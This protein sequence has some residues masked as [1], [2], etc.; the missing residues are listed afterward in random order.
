VFVLCLWCMYCFVFLLPGKTG[1][2]Y[3]SSGMLDPSH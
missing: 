1:L 3:V 2:Q